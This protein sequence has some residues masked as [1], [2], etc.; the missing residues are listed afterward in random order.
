MSTSYNFQSMNLDQYLTE[1]YSIGFQKSEYL[2]ENDVKEIFTNIGV[3]K[4]KGYSKGLRNNIFKSLDDLIVV[5][6]FDK[7]LSKVL[8][9]LSIRSEVRLKTLLVEEC[10]QRERRN[11][12][13][14]LETI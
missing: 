11:P 8:F 13:F 4:L 10:Y 9:D 2:S 6:L 1:L 5:Y 14:Y 7:F 12:F 3:F